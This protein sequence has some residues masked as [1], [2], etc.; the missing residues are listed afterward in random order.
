MG[1]DG[2]NSKTICVIADGTGRVLGVGRSGNGNHQN[3]VEEMKANVNR[4]LDEALAAA[5]VGRADIAAAC[6]GLAGA[7]R[8]AD[9]EIL[10]PIAAA[11]GLRRVQVVC[12]TYIG[13]RAG[14]DRPHGVVLVCGAGTNAMGRN[15]RGEEFQLGGFGYRYGDFGGGLILS[16]EAFRAVIRADEGRAE[17]TQLTR[18]VLERLGYASV[19][20]MKHDFLDRDLQVPVHLVMALFQA[21]R[22]GDAAAIGLLERQGEELAMSAKAVIGKLGMG[23]ETFPVVLVGSILTRAQ[24]EPWTIRPLKEALAKLA[25]KA[26]IVKL[27]VEPVIGAVLAAMDGAGH[28]LSPEQSRSLRSQ[29]AIRNEQEELPCPTSP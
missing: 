27:D 2:G 5:G 7:D 15:L 21:A 20:A 1:M 26:W 8:P 3:G 6:I 12:D 19:E 24:G 28:E 22:E 11:M 25:P 16:E 14:A 17:P 29:L 13:L 10:N 4:A 23:G 9:Y 18:R